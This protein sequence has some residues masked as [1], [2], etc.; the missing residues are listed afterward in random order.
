MG[1]TPVDIKDQT[2]DI[3][4]RMGLF[5]QIKTNRIGPERWEFENSHDVTEHSVSL[6]K[7]PDNESEIERDLLLVMR[8]DPPH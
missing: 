2:I 8:F 5:E 6:E 1:G 3:I 7:L 4:K